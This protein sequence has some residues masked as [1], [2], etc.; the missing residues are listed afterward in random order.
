MLGVGVGVGIGIG[1]GIGLDKGDEHD[2]QG[3]GGMRMQMECGSTAPLTCS[4][5]KMGLQ[6]IE[7]GRVVASNIVIYL[8]V[9]DTSPIYVYV[10]P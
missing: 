6:T 8:E 7:H 10:Y 2:T 5:G 9:V 4:V 3:I 1:V